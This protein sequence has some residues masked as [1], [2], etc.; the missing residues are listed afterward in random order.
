MNLP[1]S[2]KEMLIYLLEHLDSEDLEWDYDTEQAITLL[3]RR[4]K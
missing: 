3:V 2:L 1:T 4:L